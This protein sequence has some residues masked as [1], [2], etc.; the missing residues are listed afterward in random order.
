MRPVIALAQPR[1]RRALAH[2]GGE[3]TPI[4][5]FSRRARNVGQLQNASGNS[6]PTSALDLAR[7]GGGREK[8]MTTPK[9]AGAAATGERRSRKNSGP[10]PRVRA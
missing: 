7:S 5:G 4:P 3:V 6:G 10:R 1:A 2:P 8:P 9:G